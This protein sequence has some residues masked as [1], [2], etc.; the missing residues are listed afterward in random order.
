[1]NDRKNIY[2]LFKGDNKMDKMK[3][4]DMFLQVWNENYYN[5]NIKKCRSEKKVFVI[6][7]EKK[8]RK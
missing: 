8:D 5:Q 1:M 2:P 4:Q 7:D 3:V 6:E